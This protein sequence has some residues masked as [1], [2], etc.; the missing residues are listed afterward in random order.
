MVDI[1]D[2]QLI[3]GKDK[4]RS[5]SNM[6]FEEFSS[7]II[8]DSFFN[9]YPVD[10][11]QFYSNFNRR[12]FDC[13]DMSN[14]IKAE[15]H[16][17]NAGPFKSKEA[18]E[19]ASKHYIKHYLISPDDFEQEH[20]YH[21]ARSMYYAYV[22]DINRP[23]VRTNFNNAKVSCEVISRIQKQKDLS[24]NDSQDFVALSIIK[25]LK[26]LYDDREYDQ[27][28]YWL[29][30]LNPDYLSSKNFEFKDGSVRISDKERWHL[31][32]VWTL[33]GLKRHDEAFE[34]AQDALKKVDKFFK[35]Q[36]KEY[37][38]CIMGQVLKEERG[39]DTAV[40]GISEMCDDRAIYR[41]VK[42]VLEND[43]VRCM[44]IVHIGDDS[45]AGRR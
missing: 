42:K 10:V 18:F 1:D 11:E 6:S 45:Y 34:A 9:Q 17:G 38:Y 40:R 37:L 33:Y 39:V 30:K 21:F 8:N 20:Y 2:V 4:I 16:Y 36:N 43:R 12:S 7:L 32:M 14:L 23:S 44:K 3:L 35:R 13:T 26:R 41:K 27:M 15:E 29:N 24:I 25:V 22:K 28:L 5:N 19:N 31:Y